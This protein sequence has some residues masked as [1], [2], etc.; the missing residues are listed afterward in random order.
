MCI[1][2]D[3]SF[4]KSGKRFT[5]DTLTRWLVWFHLALVIVATFSV[6]LWSQ[7]GSQLAFS[8][9]FEKLFIVCGL[10]SLLVPPVLFIVALVGRFSAQWTAALLLLSLMEWCVTMILMLPSVQ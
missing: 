9:S 5:A 4:K 3:K 6:R 1:A 2:S 8:P 10:T 7:Q